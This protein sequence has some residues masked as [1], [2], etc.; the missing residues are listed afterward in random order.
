[1]IASVTTTV[2]HEYFH[3]DLESGLTV[4]HAFAQAGA[5]AIVANEAHNFKSKSK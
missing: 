1:M 3:M 4:L 5:T 2:D